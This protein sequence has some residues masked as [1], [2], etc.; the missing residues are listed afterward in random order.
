MDHSRTASRRKVPYRR[1]WAG[2]TSLFA[3][4][5]HIAMNVL[6]LEP[7]YGGSHRAFLDGWVRHSRHRWTVLTLPARKWKWRMRHAAVSLSDR[8]REYRAEGKT[9][10]VLITSDM[11]P[12]AEFLGLVDRPVGDLP[13]VVYFHE[14]QLT[15]PVRREDPRDLHFAMTNMTTAL[16]AGQVWFNSAYHRD[17]F[18]DALAGLLV[19][20]PDYQMPEVPGRIREKSSVEPPGIDTPAPRGLR[21][22]GPLRILWAARWEHDKNPETFFEA[23]GLLAARGVDFRISVIG[24]QFREVPPV[25]SEARERFADR[26]DRWGFQETRR[27]YESTLAEADVVVST[28]IHEFFGI[29]MV[30]A[31]AAGARPLL[32]RRLAYPEILQPLGTAADEFFHDGSAEELAA[33][34]ETLARCDDLGHGDL[35][36][37]QQTVQQFDWHHRAEAM[38]RRLDDLAG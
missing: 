15:Y 30:E 36:R 29:G 22:P 4:R 17:S 21:R 8:V 20:M 2:R 26:I 7:Y 25:F 37:L 27:E 9:W 33:R 10:D 23:V 14:N 5:N 1:I 11:L 31:M 3:E 35:K 18:L 28:A 6:A 13:T 24:Q 19:Q 32:P 38:D 34:L 12:L 16:A